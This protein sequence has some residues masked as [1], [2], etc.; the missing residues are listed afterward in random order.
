MNPKSNSQENHPQT[1]AFLQY[2]NLQKP[3]SVNPINGL[4]IVH[5][6]LFNHALR[7]TRSL[8][9]AFATANGL[10]KGWE[11][12]QKLTSSEPQLSTGG[13]ITAI[14]D[15]AVADLD[16]TRRKMA[17]ELAAF[18]GK[19]LYDATPGKRAVQRGPITEETRAF[20]NAFTAGGKA[21]LLWL[22]E[23]PPSFM[24]AASKDSGVNAGALVK[25][26]LAEVGGRGGGS[27]VSA[28]G[29]A[30]SRDA[31][32]QVEARILSKWLS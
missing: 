28:Q 18:E 1:V 2:R 6:R 23:D 21:A 7:S 29:S 10:I 24:L 3:P 16:K 5:G 25:E 11:T 12:D 32:A 22:C 4:R 8:G 17:G 30:P 14:W 19:A 15:E 31:L 20:A 27:P 26:A 13:S 9:D